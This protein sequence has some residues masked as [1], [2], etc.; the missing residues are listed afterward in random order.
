MIYLVTGMPRSYTSMVMRFLYDNGG[1]CPIQEENPDTK[2]EY[3]NYEDLLLNSFAGDQNLYDQVEKH[4]QQYDD[5]SRNTI[6]KSPLIGLRLP[7]ISRM[8]IRN[9]ISVI[10]VLRDLYTCINSNINKNKGNYQGYAVLNQQ[11][12][13]SI[14]YCP[15]PIY[16]L[17]SERL[18]GK[19]EHT[20]K[21][22]LKFCGLH[23][24]NITYSG[25]K[26]N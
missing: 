4:L 14:S 25:I 16:V 8:D 18:L 15:F 26:S 22:L 11:L 12:Y 24:R 20:A 9:G 17:L 2:G 21:T 13:L 5:Y 3:P 23:P 10:Y 19:R 6:L 1:Y 7:Q